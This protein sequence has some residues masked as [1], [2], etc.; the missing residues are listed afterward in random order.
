MDREKKLTIGLIIATTVII[1]GGAFFLTKP[2]KEKPQEAV[3]T[4]LL[5]R[6]DSQKVV[7]PNE[8]VI[9]VEFGDFQCPACAAYH[10]L[11]KQLLNENKDTLSL[12]F[13]N[14][15]LSQHKNARVSAYA[16]EA[17]GL[18]GKYWEMYDKLYENQ[19]DWSEKSDA[20]SI[21]V[22]YAKDFGLDEAKFKSDASSSEVKNKVDRDYADGVTLNVDSTPTFY[23]NAQ[24]VKNPGGLEDFKTLIEKAEPK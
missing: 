20:M 7:A 23:V 13:R 12:V 21:F 6:S 16:A 15:P 10:D 24:K 11:V 22:G 9:M 14:F 2:P 1:F 19:K 8:K 18:Q 4:E 3:S 5:I 17:A